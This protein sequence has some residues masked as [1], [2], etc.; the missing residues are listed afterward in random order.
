MAELYFYIAIE[1]NAYRTTNE[2]VVKKSAPRCNFP[3]MLGKFL[4]L[5]EVQR[6]SHHLEF[7]L[8]RV[9]EHDEFVVRVVT[10][11]V[12]AWR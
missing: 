4:D 1:N 8:R 12:F 7:R 11:R 2:F 10:L 5:D 6:G 3:Q 9:S